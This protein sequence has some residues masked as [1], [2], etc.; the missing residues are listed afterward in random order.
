MSFIAGAMILMIGV[1][2]LYQLYI[3][4]CINLK[5]LN[6]RNRI[7][8]IHNHAADCTFCGCNNPFFDVIKSI[9][10]AWPDMDTLAV[11]PLPDVMNVMYV[12]G[13][14]GKIRPM[15]KGNVA[16]VE[17]IGFYDGKVVALG[18]IDS[19]AVAMSSKGSD[20]QT[21]ELSNGQTL[22]P[23]LIEPHVHIVPSALMNGFADF[24]VFDQQHMKSSYTLDDF[25]ESLNFQDQELAKK[26]DSA[27]FWILGQG[28]DP[29]LMPFEIATGGNKNQL[30]T[31]DIDFLDGVLGPDGKPISRAIFVLS[32]SM[33]TGYINSIALKKIY[34]DDKKMQEKVR[35]QGALQEVG[36]VT[37]AL[38]AI[39]LT[40]PRQLLEL[41]FELP[42]Q[43][44]DIFT[45]G[46]ERGVTM[47]YD[48]MMKNTSLFELNRYFAKHPLTTRVGYAG[49]VDSQEAANKLEPFTKPTLADMSRPFQ[50]TIKLVSDGSNQGLTGAQS[51]AY[52]C[53][54]VDSHGMFNFQDPRA[55]PKDIVVPDNAPH[56]Q[57]IVETIIAKDW[58][59]MIHANGDAA[60]DT[61]LAVYEKALNGSSG[62]ESRH[63]I[64]HCSL[65]DQERASKMANI[66]I[67][68]S[69]LIGHVG[70]WGWT[71]SQAIFEQKAEQLD[72]CRTMW[73]KGAIITLHSDYF[74]S[75]IGPLRMMEQAVTRIME[76]APAD[77]ENRV[78]NESECLTREQALAA[79]TYNAA[80]QCH[81]EEF[82]GSLNVEM[83]ADYVILSHDPLNVPVD[84]IR[85][86]PV[87]KTYLGGRQTYPQV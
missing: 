28:V 42:K 54:A 31:I 52:C 47:M 60:I 59:L 1:I 27:S 68:P 26:K 58:P 50:A 85:D 82:V 63:R 67:S 46:A 83:L 74:V 80:W 22:L 40:A 9:S 87:E 81:V 30:A 36:E 15:L 19:V 33:H 13:A 57:S 77:Y 11:K 45:T 43:L 51:E 34:P 49:F 2:Y 73:D 61:T 17:S 71:F 78:L 56:Y 32:A 3:E 79:I 76:Q 5:I 41:V 6:K 29:S 66:G 48:A 23:G 69:F 72:L 53:E 86:I 44:Q 16:T 10:D 65:L 4:G 12:A 62:L 18:E 20:Y 37:A 70:Y 38:K 24:G 25:A 64:E 55:M 39:G 35:K 7:M 21:I 75:P 8:T 14:G 84:T